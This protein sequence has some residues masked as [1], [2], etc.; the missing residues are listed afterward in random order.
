M[1]YI[2]FH[3]ILDIA[4]QYPLFFHK[5]KIL[6]LPFMTNTIHNGNRKVPSLDPIDLDS[7]GMADQNRRIVYLGRNVVF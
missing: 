1:L 6:R 4:Q 3:I 7:H 5:L 2:Y